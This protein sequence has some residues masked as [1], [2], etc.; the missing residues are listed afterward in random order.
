[1][2]SIGLDSIAGICTLI[3]VAR[4]PLFIVQA[5]IA[6]CVVMVAF[7]ERIFLKHKLS[8]R[9]YI[10]AVIVLV[11][12]ACLG[13]ASHS[14][15]TAVVSLL[16]RNV[17]VGAPLLIVPIGA[18]AIK[19]KGTISTVILSVLSGAA[20]GGVSIIGRLLVYPSPLWLV[21]KNPLMWALCFYG[22]FGLFLFTAALQRS[23]A[24]VA[25]SVMNSAQT[26][27]PLFVGILFLGDTARN[28][29]WSLVWLGCLL[30]IGG[31]T[32]I[33]HKKETG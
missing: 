4:L 33:A 32:F 22:A 2:A 8:K 26:I 16:V 14:E 3:A 27:I 25:N 29:L 18:A 9:I 15:K 1:M 12:L 6:S 10:A 19:F 11:G 31:C 28:G 5:I 23:L 13:L 24:T 17:I 30:V 21:V 20:F 7:L